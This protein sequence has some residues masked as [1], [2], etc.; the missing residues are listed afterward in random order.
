MK[1]AIYLIG[2]LIIMVAPLIALG[3]LVYRMIMGSK[4]SDYSI[5]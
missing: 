4:G 2:F 3:W 5:K 1:Q